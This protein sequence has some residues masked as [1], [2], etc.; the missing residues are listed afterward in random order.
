M[1]GNNETNAHTNT[2][3]AQTNA[4][5]R[6]RHRQNIVGEVWSVD[7]AKL[8][9]LDDFESYP[10]YYD[11]KAVQVFLLNEE[12]KKKS[13]QEVWPMIYILREFKAD[14][15][16]LPH[17]SDYNSYGS[18][19]LP[20]HE[21]LIRTSNEEAEDVMKDIRRDCRSDIL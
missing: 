10:T 4:H 8:H 9:F 11:R 7:E 19:N 16:R 14:L 1:D 13:E 12:G 15:L 5:H 6:L 2:P 3:D 21:R 17:H 18:H 20:Y